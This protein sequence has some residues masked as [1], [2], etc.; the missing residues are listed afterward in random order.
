[1]VKRRFRIVVRMLGKGFRTRVRKRVSY[2]C[3]KD[4]FLPW[5]RT[6]SRWSCSSPREILERRFRMLERQ[7]RM[8]ER[9]SGRKTISYRGRERGAVGLV[10]LHV[11][12]VAVREVLAL[13]ERVRS[14]SRVA[15]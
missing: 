15:N 13:Q 8:V 2:T 6:W 5:A 1:M 7:F 4:D 10:H 12:S 14:M 11:R 3:E 9:R